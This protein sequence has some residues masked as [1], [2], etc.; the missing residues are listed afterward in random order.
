M[1]SDENFLTTKYFQ[2]TVISFHT[3]ARVVEQIFSHPPN[4]LSLS[5]TPCTVVSL[6][7]QFNVIIIDDH[8]ILAASPLMKLVICGLFHTGY[9]QWVYS[10]T[11]DFMNTA[12][13]YTGDKNFMVK[14]Y[15]IALFTVK[16]L[17]PV[18]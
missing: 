2:T 6:T 5:F 11:C 7:Q 15:K 3:V 9:P 17:Q 4:T 14:A 16:L 10:Y 18:H 12:T 1:I 13:Y 8:E